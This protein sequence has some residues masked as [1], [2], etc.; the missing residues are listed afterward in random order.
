MKRPYICAVIGKNFGDEGKGLA[1]DYLAMQN[2]GGKTL[3]VRHNGG[4]QSGHTVDL[5]DNR[6]VFHELSSGSFR[7][8]DTFWTDTYY[9]DLYKLGEE[10]E[11]FREISDVT[12]VIF[13]QPGTQITLIDDV[14]LNMAA[15]EA[16]GTARHGSCGMGIYEAQCRGKAGFSVTMEALWDMDE[17][18]LVKRLQEIRAVYLPKRL[19]ELGLTKASLGEYREL[20]ESN[21]VL[22][23]VAT[24]IIRNLTYVQPVR[25]NETLFLQYERIIFENGQGLLLD[26]ENETFA[27]HVT[28]SRT[29]L[30]NPCAFLK[31]YGLSLDEVIYVT[32]SYVTRHG[33]G[34]L[35]YECMAEDLGLGEPDRTNVKN[36]WQGSLRFAKHGTLEEF[37]SAVEKDLQV[38]EEYGMSLPVRGLMVTHLNETE[39]CIY[40]RGQN[41]PMNEF[42]DSPII[43][44]TFDKV[45]LSASFYAAEIRCH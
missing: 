19:Q 1:V 4:A 5:P 45:Y 39:N 32:R 16:R 43:R 21:T 38:C 36:P 25:K 14:L 27:P 2:P 12:P 7:G 28:A 40:M 37:V 9:P 44:Q 22:E 26:A 33:A 31:R 42:M 30:H 24:E 8:A 15:E 11:A 35:P 34:P 10:A 29:G 3:V 23:N 18:A 13:A 41:C 6:F 17:T 20:L